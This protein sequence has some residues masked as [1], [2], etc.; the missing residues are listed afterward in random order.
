MKGGTPLCRIDDIPRKESLAGIIKARAVSQRKKRIHRVRIQALMAGIQRN[1]SG[2]PLQGS[3]TPAARAHQSA[4]R[5][6]CKALH[7]GV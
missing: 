7:M 5:F 6:A 2:L 1:G 3:I 4:E